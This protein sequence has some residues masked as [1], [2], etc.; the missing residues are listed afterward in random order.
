MFTQK[1][2]ASEQNN[3]PHFYRTPFLSSLKI[4]NP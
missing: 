2:N 4:L 3:H 1:L